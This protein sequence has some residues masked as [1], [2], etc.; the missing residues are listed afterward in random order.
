MKKNILIAAGGT[1]GHLFPAMAVAKRIESMTNGKVGIIFAGS[2]HR[3]ESQIVPAAGYE[4]FPMNITGL[5]FSLSLKTLMLPFRIMKSISDCRKLIR[6]KDIHAV[7]CAGAYLS[8]PPGIAASKEGKP[9]FLMESNVNPG[10]SN[11]ALSGRATLIFTAFDE[12]QSFFPSELHNKL[13]PFGNPVREDILTPPGQDESRSKFNLD[14]KKKTILVFG[15]SLGAKSINHAVES[16]LDEFRETNY[17][18]LWQTGR[19][20][21]PPQN[22]PGNVVCLPFI[23]DMASAYS[24]ADL[25]ISRS[26]ATTVAEL[27]VT[28]KPSILIPL[29]SASNNEQFHNAKQLEQAGAAEI[30]EDANAGNNLKNLMLEFIADE[31]K[32]KKMGESVA[33]L[34]KPDA[35]EKCTKEILRR[36]DIEF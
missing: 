28:G 9:L 15:G 20:Y 24:A 1:G 33:K 31:G 17:Q 11:K 12:S 2:P 30:I 23:N 3:M 6:E 18:L 4:F 26:G 27:A 35:A 16:M 19:N 25:V 5:S 22:L 14:L 8:Y 29:P 7:I 21:T 13:R 34:A 32:L 10:K 36:L